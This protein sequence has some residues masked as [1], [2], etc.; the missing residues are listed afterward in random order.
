MVTF[1]DGCGAQYKS[2]L[3]FYHLLQLQS[4]SM[5]VEKASFSSNHG[6]SLCDASGGVIKSMAKRAVVT[7]CTIIHNASDLFAF[8]DANLVLPSAD[9]P[10]RSCVHTTQSFIKLDSCD[11]D[12]GTTSSQMKTVKGCDIDRGTTSSQMKT[13]KGCDID[14]GTTSSQINTVKGCDIDRGT[15]SS[16][17]KTVKGCDIDRGTTSSQMKTVKGCDIDRGTTSSQMKTVK[18]TM[19]VHSIQVSSNGS[20]MLH[21]W[22]C[23]CAQRPDGGPACCPNKES[24][25]DW[26]HV[27]MDGTAKATAQATICPFSSN[28]R[29]ICNLTVTNSHSRHS[30]MP[31]PSPRP[32]SSPRLCHNSSK[33]PSRFKL[34]NFSSSLAPAKNISLILVHVEIM[35]VDFRQSHIFWKSSQPCRSWG[36]LFSFRSL[37]MKFCHAWINSRFCPVASHF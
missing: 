28:C 4:P 26:Q 10:N 33:S 37:W 34:P 6:K 21:D 25:E 35:A 1:S 9:G 29:T 12:R 19:K 17:M 3:P 15:T 5:T 24:V 14:R 23:V 11:I 27:W 8:C 16:Q 2:R 13:V 22:A 30:H 18:G 7:G 31:S 36:H 32:C 20:L